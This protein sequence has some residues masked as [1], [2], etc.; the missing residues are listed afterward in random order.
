MNVFQRFG[1]HMNR[2]E[3]TSLLKEIY[4]VCGGLGEKAVMLMPPDADNV[5]S[6]GYQLHIKA[7]L[8]NEH[9]DCV[10]PLVQKYKLNMNYEPE[11]ELLVIY[12]P[13]EKK[14]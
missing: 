9:L 7:Y 2:A 10:K 4:W 3:A 12:R 5:L 8:G 1:E 11:H 6:Q 13:I 14:T